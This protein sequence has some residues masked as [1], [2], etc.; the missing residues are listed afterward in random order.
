MHPAI[1]SRRDLIAKLLQVVRGRGVLE[2]RPDHMH[3]RQRLDRIS[4]VFMQFCNLGLE[5]DALADMPLPLERVEPD[6]RGFAY[7]GAGMGLFLFDH[8]TG[9][10]EQ[11]LHSFIQG[12]GLAYTQLLYVGAGV[13]LARLRKGV[14]ETIERFDDDV[15]AWAIVDGYG[16]H[17]GYFW[18]Q[19]IRDQARSEHLSG[20]ASRAFDHGLG[21]AIWFTRSADVERI[22]ETVDRFEPSRQADLWEGVGLACGYAG[23][24]TPPALARLTQAAAPHLPRLAAGL[25]V[26]TE[27]RQRASN[28]VPHTEVACRFIWKRSAEEVGRLARG[29]LEA[30]PAG[31][32]DA[33]Y[34]AWRQELRRTFVAEVLALES[35]LTTADGNG[36]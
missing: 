33:R 11:R 21:R 9:F 17:E 13:G 35:N 20:Y 4:S 14:S 24:L 5:S 36:K 15:L 19:Y 12:P 7:E 3:L 2:P 28:I 8:L 26:A 25:A 10:R 32:G 16:F 34:E 6:L 31:R 1:A 18:P 30:T 23:A 22:K 27:L 29:R